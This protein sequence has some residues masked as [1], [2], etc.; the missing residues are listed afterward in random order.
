MIFFFVLLQQWYSVLYDQSLDQ[1]PYVC[2]TKFP[3]YQVSKYWRTIPF[4]L[5]FSTLFVQPEYKGTLS[6]IGN[7][8]H[9]YI[10][11]GFSSIKYLNYMIFLSDS[12][13]F[14]QEWPVWFKTHFFFILTKICFLLLN[15]NSIGLTYFVVLLWQERWA[16]K[17]LGL[18]REV[19]T[20]I[21]NELVYFLYHHQ[22]AHSLPFRPEAQTWANLY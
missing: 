10:Y 3:A 6:F 11:I 17:D 18:M 5:H 15:G 4:F 21:A 13:I 20:G 8:C 14:S 12:L 9:I 16:Q 19:I 2:H 7:H 22:L 1:L